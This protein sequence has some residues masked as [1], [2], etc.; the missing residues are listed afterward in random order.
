MFIQYR[1]LAWVGLVFLALVSGA[2]VGYQYADGR[3][4]A[5][6]AAAQERALTEAR[7]R[8]EADKQAA[9]ETARREA[10]AQERARAVRTKGVDDAA[11]KA[12]ASCG[13]DAESFGLLMEALNSA[14]GTET[15][16]SG[17]PVKV[18]QRTGTEGWLRPRNSS[19]G[20][21]V[22]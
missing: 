17:V 10:V 21:R 2:Y 7:Q 1:L 19:L 14:N 4:A 13:R 11:K 8:A 20:V 22:D 5:A 18:P 9:V 12:S 15:G 3:N 16:S 6:A